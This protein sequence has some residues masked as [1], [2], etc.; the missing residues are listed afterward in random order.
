MYC[1][2]HVLA[3][4]FFYEENYSFLSKKQVLL[5]PKNFNNSVQYISFIICNVFRDKF[6]LN[7][8]LTDFKAHIQVIFCD[9]N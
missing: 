1:M 4:C 5:I 3:M 6:S 9:R 8:K 7:K 2:L